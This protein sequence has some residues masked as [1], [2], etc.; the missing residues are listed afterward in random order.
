MSVSWDR[1]RARLKSGCSSAGI[2]AAWNRYTI[3]GEAAYFA[4]FVGRKVR[5]RGISLTSSP[6]AGKEAE[7]LAEA[8]D[9]GVAECTS[10]SDTR[11]YH[12]EKVDHTN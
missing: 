1:R 3:P 4:D 10:E 9:V 5:V 8:H 11:P 7:C 6:D 12:R 2:E